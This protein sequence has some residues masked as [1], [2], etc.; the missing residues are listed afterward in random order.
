MAKCA[1]DIIEESFQPATSS[2]SSMSF[3]GHRQ[4]ILY[5]Y[6]LL[7]VTLMNIM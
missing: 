3:S 5:V 1:E 7:A 4:Q 6:F 2:I